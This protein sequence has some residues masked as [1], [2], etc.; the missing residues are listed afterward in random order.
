MCL[1]ESQIQRGVLVGLNSDDSV[2]EVSKYN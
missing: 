1:H 2:L